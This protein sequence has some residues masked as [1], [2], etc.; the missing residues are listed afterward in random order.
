M[1]K[2]ETHVHALYSSTCS[3]LSAEEIVDRYIDAGF[4]AIVMTDHY[5][6]RTTWYPEHEH[7]TKWGRIENFFKG[8]ELAREYGA[9]KGLKVYKG[10]E[11]RFHESVNDYLLYNYEDELLADPDWL[12]EAGLKNFSPIAR[13]AGA[14][15]IQAHPCRCT[16]SPPCQPAPL[17]LLDG[18]EVYNACKRHD[19][20]NN[21]AMALAASDS[22]LIRIAGSDCHRPEDV[23][24]GGILSDTLPADEAELAALLR[25]GD[26]SLIMK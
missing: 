7:G 15:L 25:S 18:I 10:A 22:R 5:N 3:I 19:S 2:I 26:Y 11:I 6:T 20:Q 1:Y 16:S 9:R 12:F 23:G 21:K 24:G 13:S 4:S 8:Y 17:E 14:L